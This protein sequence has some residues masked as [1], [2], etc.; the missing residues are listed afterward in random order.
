[1]V[2]LAKAEQFTFRKGP[3]EG[4]TIAEIGATD[5]GLRY[6]DQAR[7]WFPSGTY[8]GD[9]LT[10]YFAAEGNE[11]RLERAITAGKHPGDWRYGG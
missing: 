7:E 1:M 2:S 11:Q 9:C 6:L 5:S 8:G 10:A 3:H 4:K